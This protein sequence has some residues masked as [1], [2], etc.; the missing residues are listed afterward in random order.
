MSIDLAAIRARCEAATP[1]PWHF[2]PNSMHNFII[3][4]DEYEAVVSIDP[5]M[6][7]DFDDSIDISEGDG[8]FIVAAR[9]DIPLLLAEIERLR[10]LVGPEASPVAGEVT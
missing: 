4:N 7:D 1:G 8:N 10:A 3:E 6:E 9:T 2:D 5:G